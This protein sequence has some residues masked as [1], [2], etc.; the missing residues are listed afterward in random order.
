MY[1]LI[2]NTLTYRQYVRFWP[3]AFDVGR[4]QAKVLFLL[5]VCE[6]I[7][8]AKQILYQNKL[9]E[10]G[11]TSVLKGVLERKSG[12]ESEWNAVF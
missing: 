6:A 9:L 12:E 4:S 7:G 11:D 8:W 5:A 10:C 1:Y 2:L 3:I